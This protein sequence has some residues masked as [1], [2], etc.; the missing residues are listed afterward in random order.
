LNSTRAKLELLAVRG[1]E[2]IFRAL[3]LRAARGVGAGLGG[4]VG[5]LG[6]R[7]QVALDQLN[8]ALPELSDTERRKI[9]NGVYRSFGKTLAEFSRLPLLNPQNINSLMEFHGLDVMRAAIAEG[10]GVIGVS[11]HLGNWEWM[12]AGT[13][14]SGIPLTYIVASQ[15]NRLIEERMD[16]LRKGCGIEIVNRTDNAAK[17][18]LR[19]LRN[20]HLVAILCDQDAH[21]DGVFVPY[22]GRL[23]STPRGAM[24]FALRT[25]SPVFFTEGIR[26]GQ[27]FRVTYERMDMSDLPEDH[28]AAVTEGMARI[29]ARL[30]KSV[31]AFP[32]QW[33]WLHRR[34]KTR[35]DKRVTG[36]G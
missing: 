26:I 9:V 10:K 15:T 14:L 23:A 7:K 36:N 22:F 20:G 12:G 29:T 18:T 16:S 8:L 21:E 3:P 6:I 27:T 19:A 34:W 2:A 17:G 33:L 32:D 31:R 13:A 30:E 1:I 25:G 24:V 4:L 28:E 35:P 5:L 11:G